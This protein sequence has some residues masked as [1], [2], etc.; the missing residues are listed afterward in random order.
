MREALTGM[1][2]ESLMHLMRQGLPADDEARGVTAEVRGHL[3]ICGFWQD[4]LQL[5]E[6][7]SAGKLCNRVTELAAGGIGLGLAE[8]LRLKL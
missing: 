6:T 5:D 3:Q 4:V 2:D 8:K 1:L 7:A